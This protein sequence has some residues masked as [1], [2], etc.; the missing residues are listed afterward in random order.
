MEEEHTLAVIRVDGGV[1]T[2]TRPATIGLTWKPFGS[3]SI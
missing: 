1:V 2:V 3:R